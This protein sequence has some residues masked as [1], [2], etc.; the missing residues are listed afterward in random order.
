MVSTPSCSNDPAELLETFLERRGAELSLRIVLRVKHQHTDPPYPLGLLRTRSERPRDCRAAEERDQLA[1]CRMIKLHSVPINQ[2]QLAGYRFGEDQ[3][4]GIRAF[5]NRS[6]LTDAARVR[7]GS[8]NETARAVGRLRRRHGNSRILLSEPRLLT[9]RS[10][11][12]SIRPVSVWLLPCR[13]PSAL[14]R[15]RFRSL[16]FCG[17]E[18]G[19]G[20][21]RFRE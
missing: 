19:T 21:V 2:G 10:S 18:A 15:E 12:R 5:H 16:A 13:R 3:S 9:P 8:L 7:L 4:A 1:P 6:L 11:D 17:H 20:H 14:P